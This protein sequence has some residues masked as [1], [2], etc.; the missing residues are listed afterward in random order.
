MRAGPGDHDSRSAGA[1]RMLIEAGLALSSEL[2]LEAILA[3]IV[4]L[5]AEITGAR[6]G[7][8]GVLGEDGRI[9]QFVT[10]GI[11]DEQRRS[12]GRLPEGKG[13]LGILVRERRVV[14]IRDVGADPRSAG[15]PPN[16]PVMRSF[17]GAPILSRGRV[18]GNLYLTDKRGAPEFTE[19]DERAVEVLATQAGVAIDN[20]RLYEEATRRERWLEAVHEITTQVLGGAD[21]RE[22]LHTIAR[23][24]RELANADLAT[25]A[26]PTDDGDRLVL[27][28]AVGSHADRLRGTVFPLEGSVSGEVI[29]FARAAILEDASK[30][31]RVCQPVVRLGAVGPAMFVPLSARGKA[32]GTL[33]V[34]RIRDGP[35]FAERDLALVET[36]AGQA[37][38]ALEYERARREVE[39][40]IV[41]EDRERIAREL[42]DGVIQSLFAV[43]MGLQAT[44]G[45]ANDPEVARRIEDAT[46]DLDRV[47]RDLRNY[48]FGLRPGILAD[49]Q[50]EQALGEMAKDFE[51]R[52]GVVTVAEVDPQVAAELAS[53]AADVVQ[54]A[55]EALSNVGRHA[56]AATCRLRLQ[57]DGDR[58]V[59]EVDDDGCGFDPAAPDRRGQGLENLRRRA[60][61]LA[62]EAVIDS[63]PGNGTTVRISLPL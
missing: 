9:A 7:A 22:T 50:L 17:L 43:G 27:E 52:T 60:R 30:D 2:S 39:R 33:L 38:V 25:I 62:G 48:I 14:R 40:L 51:E 13:I 61:D 63:A 34:A 29:R 47:I 20:A 32:F 44:A 11:T 8:L 53:R 4:E 59:L 28:A 24:A 1:A 36:F 55:R 31:P 37:A 46:A 56:G 58:A 18:F 10:T 5:A 45:L 41:L 35:P 49:R 15:F 12:I 6:Y 57:R 3:R 26:V 21:A 23:R 42:H 19:D 16:H 54:M